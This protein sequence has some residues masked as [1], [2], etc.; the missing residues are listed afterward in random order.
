MKKL[1]FTI[2]LLKF[3]KRKSIGL[4]GVEGRGYGEKHFCYMTGKKS[5]RDNEGKRE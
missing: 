2:V 5:C 4:G 1:I 3:W